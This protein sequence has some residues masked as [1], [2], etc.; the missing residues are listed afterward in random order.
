MELLNDTVKGTICYAVKKLKNAGVPDSRSEAEIILAGIMNI[1]RWKLYS[2]ADDALLPGVKQAFFRAI[3]LRQK[4][5]PLAYITGKKEFYGFDFYV[6]PEVLIPRPETEFLIDAVIGWAKGQVN[7]D[8]DRKIKIVD[9]GT[10]SGSI[11]V[12]LALLLPRS[13][14]WAVDVSPEALRIAQKNACVH[15]V[16]RRI[17]LME[18]S[19]WE[20]FSGKQQLFDVIVSNPPYICSSN[21][22][23]LSPD[24]KEYE[25]R[26]ALDGGKD[27][28]DGYRH[29][30]KKIKLFASSPSL[31]VLEVGAG[32]F[33]SVKDLCQRESAITRVQSL[34]DYLGHDRVLLGFIQ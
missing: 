1:E 27:G 4:H 28:L 25:P 24:I 9:L 17:T 21:I 34:K 20:A 11:V 16:Q 18:G 2:Q 3:E 30:L 13:L 12:T 15:G 5:C 31:L 22:E 32:S 8:E 7:N 23:K 10:G 14:L 29:I 6:T 26:K 19:Y 33:K